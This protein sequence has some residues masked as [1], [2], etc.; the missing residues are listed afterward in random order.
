MKVSNLLFILS[1]FIFAAS[2]ASA[3]TTTQVKNVNVAEFKKLMLEKDIVVVDVRTPKEFAQGSIKDAVNIPLN[4]I[5]SKVS[6][7]SK[8]KRYLVFCRSGVRSRRASNILAKNGI[9]VI[10][11]LG[12][13]LAYSRN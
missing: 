9:K 8:E 4:T 5:S 11:L 3:Q 1:F 6:E 10:N 12:G 7:F 13:Y 2:S